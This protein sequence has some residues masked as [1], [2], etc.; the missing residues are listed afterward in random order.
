MKIGADVVQNRLMRQ[1]INNA[2]ARVREGT[3]LSAGSEHQQ[4]LPA[5]HPQSHRQWR[6]H[7]SP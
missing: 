2:T 7:R 3:S 5:D 4:T 6:K 1:A